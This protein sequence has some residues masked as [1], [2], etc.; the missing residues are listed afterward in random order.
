MILRALRLLALVAL[1]AATAL[2]L[3]RFAI[4]PLICARATSRA[5][6][7][8]D[9]PQPRQAALRAVAALSDCAPT[10]RGL[11]TVAQAQ[12]ILGDRHAAIATYQRALEIDRRPEI[13]FAL[14]ME[15][16]ELLDRPAAIRN[17]ARACAFDPARLQDIPYRDVRRE[18]RMRIA[19]ATP[20][21]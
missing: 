13:Y 9:L 4:A 12:S 17:L 14:G 3:H 16:L 15:Q 11:F 2:A 5:S 8:L 1:L 20:P 19:A 18:V 6:A 10:V 7:E 21:L